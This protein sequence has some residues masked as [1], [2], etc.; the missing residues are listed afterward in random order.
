LILYGGI[1]SALNCQLKKGNIAHGQNG[2][3]ES[4]LQQGQYG[5]V[6]Y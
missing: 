1:A 5:L 6:D 2:P 3:V 4:Y